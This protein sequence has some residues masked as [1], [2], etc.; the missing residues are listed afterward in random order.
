MGRSVDAHRD[1]LMMV[2]ETNSVSFVTSLVKLVNQF[3][4]IVQVAVLLQIEY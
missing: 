4:R 3:V 1:I 2:K